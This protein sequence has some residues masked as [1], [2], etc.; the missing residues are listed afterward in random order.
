ME[1]LAE[2]PRTKGRDVSLYAIKRPD[3]TVIEESVRCEKEESWDLG[4]HV[5]GWAARS[6][7]LHDLCEAGLSLGY[8]LV[9]VKV[10]EIEEET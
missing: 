3:G 7:G 1:S 10:V 6:Y 4:W 8:R 5:I 9:R 2:R